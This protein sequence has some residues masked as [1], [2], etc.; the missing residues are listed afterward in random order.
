MAAEEVSEGEWRQR[1][2]DRGVKRSS[3]D[4]LEQVGFSAVR[5]RRR[6]RDKYREDHREIETERETERERER[7]RERENHRENVLHSSF[8]SFPFSS[9]YAIRLTSRA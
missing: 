8:V 7:Q 3:V 6:R 5:R 9:S 1:G 2:R 4:C